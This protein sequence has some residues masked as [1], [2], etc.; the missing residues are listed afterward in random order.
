MKAVANSNYL[1]CVP[2]LLN[3]VGRIAHHVRKGEERKEGK[4][5]DHFMPVA[6]GAMG[7]DRKS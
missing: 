3:E 7:C 2:L 4:D 5:G 6:H 1:K